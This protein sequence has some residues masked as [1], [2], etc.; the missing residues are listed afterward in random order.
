MA[1][2]ARLPHDRGPLAP[3]FSTSLAADLITA[4]HARVIRSCQVQAVSYQKALFKLAGKIKIDPDLRSGE[5][6]GSGE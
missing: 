1:G 4:I 5:G 2:R 3:R 6:P